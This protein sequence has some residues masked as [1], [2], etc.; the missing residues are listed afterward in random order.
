[1][2][3]TRSRCV[4]PAL[5]EEARARAACSPRSRAR[6]PGCCA[7]A[8]SWSWTTARPT[9][10]PRSR[11][12]AGATVVRE[13]RRGY[14]AACLAGSRALRRDPP[15]VV[16]FLDADCSDDPARAAAAARAD[17]RR[18]RRPGD[19][20]A[21]ARR[22]ASRARSRRCRRFGNRLATALLRVLFGARFTDLGP[23]RAIRWEA[24]ERLGMR[25]R[26]FG[27]TVEMQARAL[28]APGCA[29]VEVPV[30]YR[31]RRGG[32]LEGLGHAARRDRAPGW[33]I[34]CTIARV[35]LG[36]R[37]AP[38]TSQRTERGSD[39]HTTSA[40]PIPGGASTRGPRSRPAAARER[41]RGHACPAG[42]VSAVHTGTGVHR[43]SRL[44]AA[45][46]EAR[47]RRPSGSARRS[48]APPPPPRA[49]GARASV[50][51]VAVVEHQAVAHQREQRRGRRGMRRQIDAVVAVAREQSRRPPPLALRQSSIASS[52][53]S[54]SSRL[55]DEQ[56]PRAEVRGDVAVVER[57]FR[58]SRCPTPPAAA[59]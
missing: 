41:P 14:G 29:C 2:T 51:R 49:R 32:P 3:R 25:D 11:A 24:L 7:C 43:H 16:A 45:A 17:P 44:V 12:P 36:R 53:L 48:R 1:M 23:F 40:R 15:D 20:L 39:P 21:R 34:L 22:R 52:T 6:A 13:P 47:P 58:R 55:A 59:Q 33:K 19:R 27:W 38:T 30:R 50:E 5:D 18:P 56:R 10:P 4:I 42:S 26:D 57:A 35:R 8:R 9:A 46:P 28:R 37:A 54:A 31:R